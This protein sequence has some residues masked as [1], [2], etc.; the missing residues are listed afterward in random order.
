M[1]VHV[2][3]ELCQGH[4]ICSMVAP[5][6]FILDD[7]DG[8]ATAVDGDVSSDQ[9]PKVQEALRSCPERAIVER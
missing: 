9:I 7:E 2:Q 5:D 1:K 3:S 8:H 4:T 6:I